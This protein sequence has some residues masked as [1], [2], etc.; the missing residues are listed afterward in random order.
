MLFQCPKHLHLPV[1][2]GITISQVA[3]AF[4]SEVVAADSETIV[5]RPLSAE[6]LSI[7]ADLLNKH[8]K[9]PKEPLISAFTTEY[10]RMG[11]LCPRQ[12]LERGRRL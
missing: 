8:S 3:I 2:I 11:I 12:Y 7:E 4:F 10:D 1:L 9:D 6:E 5:H